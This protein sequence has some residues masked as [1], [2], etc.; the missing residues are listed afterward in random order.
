MTIEIADR[1]C[2]YRKAAG[3][4][5]EELAEKIGVSRQAVSKWERAE[6][7]PDT[8]NL[9]LLSKIYGVTLDDLLNC[10]PSSKNET[11]EKTPEAAAKSDKSEEYDEDEE[12]GHT[13]ISFKDG[14]HINDKKGDSVHIDWSGVHVHSRR[15]EHVDI[16]FDGIHVEEDGHLYVYS[17]KDGV[18]VNSEE[19]K[20]KTTLATKRRRF[21]KIWNM[22][23]YPVIACLFFF[24][25]GFYNILGG[26]STSWILF[27]T[28]PVYYSIGDMIA[29][30]DLG[31][32]CYP[33]FITVVY[34]YLGFLEGL[35][36]PMWLLYITVPVFYF[37]C[38]F[39][40][41]IFRK[42]KGLDPIEEEEDGED[43]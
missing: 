11:E 4:S 40:K 22:V 28:V 26:W 2:A 1:L 32:F 30:R 31:R 5:Q 27:I 36:H 29:H 15:G 14:I 25:F 8:D 10:D 7:S 39:V 3:F 17:D 23:P 42:E 16:S 38:D 9:I 24:I 35:W 20:K 34:L 37:L 13:R 21:K 19:V 33:I 18:H 12:A 6:A 41:S 43:E